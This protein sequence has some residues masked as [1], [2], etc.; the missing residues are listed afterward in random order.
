MWIKE[1]EEKSALRGESGESGVTGAEGREGCKEQGVWK[2]KWVER[3]K[4][5]HLVGQCGNWKWKSL[6]RVWLCDPMNYTVH[7][8]LQARMLEWVAF[9]FSRGSSQSRD[10]SLVSHLAGRSFTSWATRDERFRQQSRGGRKPFEAALSSQRHWPTSVPGR[11][12]PTP[13]VLVPKAEKVGINE[14][15]NQPI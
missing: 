1:R 7:G 5:K 8:I 14:K 3:R 11:A 12:Q 13:W 2:A 9:P 6:S 15:F 10:W 4:G